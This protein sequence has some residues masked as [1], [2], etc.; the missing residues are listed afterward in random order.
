[1]IV[2]ASLKVLPQSYKSREEDFKLVDH[3]LKLI[4]ESNIKFQMGPSETTVEGE[5][6][7]VLKVIETIQ[8][9]YYDKGIKSFMFEIALQYNDE[10]YYIDDKLNNISKI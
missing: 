4:Q 1:M 3:A 6:K 2:Q 10:T 7:E 5:L 8:I 9:F